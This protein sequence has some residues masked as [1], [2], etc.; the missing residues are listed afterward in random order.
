MNIIPKIK[1]IKY[2]GE[3]VNISNINWT[4]SENI[5]GRL[6]KAADKI[7]KSVKNGFDVYVE[8]GNDKS[9]AYTIE[10]AKK[11]ISIKSSGAAGAFYG[12]KTF[13]AMLSENNGTVL[14]GKF[15]SGYLQSCK[16][17]WKTFH[18]DSRS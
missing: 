7:T 16:T 11:R 9:E 15:L 18:R 3:S 8:A 17:H 6:V 14:S 13:S 4:F 2:T 12:L 10:I 5:D 1:N